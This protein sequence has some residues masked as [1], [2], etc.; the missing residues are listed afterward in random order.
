[1][2]PIA[3]VIRQPPNFVQNR[4]SARHHGRLVRSVTISNPFL[5][6]MLHDGVKVL[7][8][9]SSQ[10]PQPILRCNIIYEDS[11]EIIRTG[12][13]VSTETWQDAFVYQIFPVSNVASHV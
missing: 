6:V 11:R 13:L 9:N 7:L 10:H 2:D 1:M 3:H 12:T 5:H 8:P 4:R